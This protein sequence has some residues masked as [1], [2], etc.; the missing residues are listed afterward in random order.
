M[1]KYVD[2]DEVIEYDDIIAGVAARFIHFQ[3]ERA[4]AHGVSLG[5][6]YIVNKGL[7]LFGDRGKKAA[8]KELNQLHVREC[9]APILISELTPEEKKKVQECIMF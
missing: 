3:N 5:Q 9:F 4:M 8:L 2:D 6:Q 1:S 7:K